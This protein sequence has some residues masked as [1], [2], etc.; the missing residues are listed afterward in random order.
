MLNLGH[1]NERDMRPRRLRHHWGPRHLL[2]LQPLKCSRRIL[3]GS[4]VL[5][6]NTQNVSRHERIVIKDETYKCF[7]ICNKYK[8]ALIFTGKGKISNKSYNKSYNKEKWQKTSCKC[9]YRLA[10]RYQLEKREWFPLDIATSTGRYHLIR[11]QIW[12]R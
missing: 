12:G 3:A 4:L 6:R 10:G 2:G 11:S 9:V 8:S 7:R 1:E 5:V